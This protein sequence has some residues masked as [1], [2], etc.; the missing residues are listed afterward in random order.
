VRAER[1]GKASRVYT[2]TVESRDDAGNVSTRVVTVTV[3]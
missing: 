1:T 2:V 3:R